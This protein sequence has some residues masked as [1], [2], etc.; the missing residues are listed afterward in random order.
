MKCV[1]YTRERIETLPLS[2]ASRL[3]GVQF[4]RRIII[5][6]VHSICYRSLT[7]AA[8]SPNVFMSREHDIFLD[9]RS[10]IVEFE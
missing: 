7:S 10:L 5:V 4:A 2:Y 8:E 1:A 9:R 3:G 6:F